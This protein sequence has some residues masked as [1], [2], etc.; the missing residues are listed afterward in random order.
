MAQRGMRMPQ[1][2]PAMNA[3][4]TRLIVL[5]LALFGLPASVLA[6]SYTIS[7]PPYLLAQNN[8]GAIINNA[9]VWTYNAGTTTA[10]TTYSDNAGTANANPIRSDSA[11]RFTEIGRASCRERV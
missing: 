6:Q 5:L 11:G 10:A 7:P 4:S 2:T 3:I 9:C 1:R 8:S